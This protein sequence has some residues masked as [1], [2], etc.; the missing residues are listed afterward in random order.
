MKIRSLNVG[1]PTEVEWEGQTVTT[2][3]YKYPVEGEVMLRRLNLDG[4]G[5]ADLTVHGGETK[6]VYVYPIEHYAFWKSQFP[7]MDLPLG[8]FGENLTTEGLFEDVNIGDR[9][10]I[11][12]AEVIVTEPRMPC[13]KLGIRFGRMDVLKR[14]L[15]SEL[16]GFYF[17]VLKEGLV[18]AGDEIIPVHR[19]KD[20]LSITEVT[21]LYST[22]RTNK[23]LLEKAIRTPLLP[24]SWRYYFDGQLM[25]LEGRPSHY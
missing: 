25:R 22:E 6:A 12:E 9:F 5:Q 16:T 13:Y 18:Q 10:Q 14:F 15:R 7:D 8:M 1:L 19:E 20:G 23:A 21:R 2:G 4:D 11:G 24:E 17:G 3:I